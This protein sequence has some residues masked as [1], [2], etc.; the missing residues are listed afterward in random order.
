MTLAPVKARWRKQ[1]KT[2][3]NLAYTKLDMLC[4]ENALTRVTYFHAL[5]QHYDGQR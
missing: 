2:H 3:D 5:M 1:A 4:G